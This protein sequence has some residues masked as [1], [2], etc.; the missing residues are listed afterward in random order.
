MH[1]H[2]R[3][4]NILARCTHKHAHEFIDVHARVGVHVHTH[5]HVHLHLHFYCIQMARLTE[6]CSHV[7]RHLPMQIQ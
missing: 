3:V 6:Q 1:V 2:M 5:V 7:Y 4:W